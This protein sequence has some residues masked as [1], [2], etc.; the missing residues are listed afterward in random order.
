MSLDN[1]QVVSSKAEDPGQSQSQKDSLPHSHPSTASTISVESS[2]PLSQTSE[3]RAY[4]RD[5]SM[6]YDEAQKEVSPGDPRAFDS[7]PD[8]ALEMYSDDELLQYSTEDPRPLVGGTFYGTSSKIAAR[9][10]D[11]SP[12]TPKPPLGLAPAPTVP[13]VEKT[14]EPEAVPET[15]RPPRISASPDHEMVQCSEG[16]DNDSGSD[17]TGSIPVS[18]QLKRPAT[19]SSEIFSSPTL[20]RQKSDEP[21]NPVLP[22]S[23]RDTVPQTPEYVMDAAEINS[24]VGPDAQGKA[25]IP[26]VPADLASNGENG[27]PRLGDGFDPPQAGLVEPRQTATESGI[28]RHHL[29]ATSV[30][31][32]QH[33]RCEKFLYQVSMVSTGTGPKPKPELDAWTEALLRRGNEHENAIVR[34]L[35][36]HATT[37]PN[38]FFHLFQNKDLSTDEAIRKI[39]GDVREAYEKRWGKDSGDESG[40]QVEEVEFWYSQLPLKIPSSIA[41]PPDNIDD[42]GHRFSISFGTMFPDFLVIRL[43]PVGKRPGERKGKDSSDSR[44]GRDSLDS[45]KGKD[46]LDSRKGKD[47]LDFLAPCKAV[48]EWF[49]VD[50]K[51]SKRGRIEIAWG[52][53]Q[54]LIRSV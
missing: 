44:K 46:S 22:S 1:V 4:A 30:A 31:Q 2:D 29:T 17:S 14:P 49:V 41:P 13:L 6:G 9:L 26:D 47:S 24:N 45:R 12:P 39:M 15:R 52:R 20:K 19:P 32:H 37:D 40:E 38:F 43:R 23:A 53:V 42:D 35:E 7:I 18:P 28:R 8:E 34:S 48:A 5:V 33:F 16:E 3:V 25:S 54:R 27:H 21:S 50:A 11:P 10:P 51:S 36:N